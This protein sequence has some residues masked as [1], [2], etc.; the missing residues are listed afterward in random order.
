[1]ILKLFP[2]TSLILLAACSSYS[3]HRVADETATSKNNTPAAKYA[4]SRNPLTPVNAIASSNNRCVDDFNFLRQAGGEKYQKYSQDYIKIGEGYRFLNTNKN[5]M[6]SDA[7]EV[8]TMKLDMV[9]D[10]L[11]TRVNYAG[12]EVVK[13]KIKEINVI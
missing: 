3:G 5:I 10:T 1:M 11:C 4:S 12:F 8:Y 13:E 7:K 2:V 6:G 9:L